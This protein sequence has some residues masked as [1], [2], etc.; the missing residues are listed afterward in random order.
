MSY[1]DSIL[2]G[3]FQTDLLESRFG[4]DRKLSGSNYMVTVSDVL[5]SGKKKKVKRLLKLY[6]VS[7]GTINIRSYVEKF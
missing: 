5:L 1:C 4:H 2:T 3:I 7:K 6:L